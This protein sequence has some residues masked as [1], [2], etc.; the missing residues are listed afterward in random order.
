MGRTKAR[1]L[2]TLVVLVAGS[3]LFFAGGSLGEFLGNALTRAIPS[4][5]PWPPVFFLFVFAVLGVVL[6]GAMGKVVLRHLEGA[7]PP[8]VRPGRFRK[9]FAYLA[10][11]VGG[12]LVPAIGVLARVDPDTGLILVFLAAPAGLL[13]ARA[14]L[15]MGSSSGEAGA[16]GLPAPPGN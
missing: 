14:I 16:E 6:A 2:S 5:G 12:F 9:L 15:R 3:L 13:I 11:A 7:S 10:G 1:L 4:I 8:G